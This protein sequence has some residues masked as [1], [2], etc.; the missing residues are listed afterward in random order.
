VR[1][2]RFAP[3]AYRHGVVEHDL[4]IDESAEASI[5]GR[6]GEGYRVDCGHLIRSTFS[7][8]GGMLAGHQV[9]EDTADTYE[10]NL[11]LP[12]ARRLVA[13][14]HAGKAAGGDKRG[15]QLAALLV[16]DGQDYPRGGLTE[17]VASL[18]FMVGLLFTETDQIDPR[19]AQLVG[20]ELDAH[21]S[22]ARP[23]RL[24]GPVRTIR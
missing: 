18:S 6:G 13:A 22:A 24:A 7:V 16:L 14:M 4:A 12:F 15:K 8:A 19:G 3:V 17:I 20:G 11:A 9:I 2:E 21:N 1:A 23:L 5:G 10:A